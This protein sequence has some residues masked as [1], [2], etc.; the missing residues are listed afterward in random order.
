MTPQNQPP[1]L[2]DFWLDDFFFRGEG[3]FLRGFSQKAGAKC[4]FLMVSLW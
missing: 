1:R 3:A 4:G 2:A